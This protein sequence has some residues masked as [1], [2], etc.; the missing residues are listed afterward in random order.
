MDFNELKQDAEKLC[1][2]LKDKALSCTCALV[3]YHQQNDD[4]HVLR[5]YGAE[6]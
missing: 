6:Q 5:N 1:K 2:E 3:D 4:K